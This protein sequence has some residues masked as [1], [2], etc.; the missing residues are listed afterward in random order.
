[1]F[2]R[3][4]SVHVTYGPLLCRREIGFLKTTGYLPTLDRRLAPG[5]YQSRAGPNYGRTKPEHSRTTALL[6]HGTP[7]LRQS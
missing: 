1:M 2:Q 5:Q 7:G 6:K 3:T 4:T